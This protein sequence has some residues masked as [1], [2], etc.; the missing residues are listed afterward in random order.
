MDD[1]L[2]HL[3]LAENFLSGLGF[4]VL[5]ASTVDMAESMQEDASAD[6]ILLD[7][8]LPERDGWSFARQL[9]AGEYANTPIAMISGHAHE[10]GLHRSEIGLHDAFLAKPYNLDDLLLRIAELLQIK[11]VIKETETAEP[12]TE[13]PKETRENLIE[14]AEIGHASAIRALLVELKASRAGSP[15]LFRAIE[16]KLTAFDMSGLIDLLSEQ[17]SHD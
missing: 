5:C 13:L 1:D 12:H 2:N 9:R 10:E 17:M 6:I 4:V 11:L 16:T 14:L 7:I 3:S 15:D 8:D